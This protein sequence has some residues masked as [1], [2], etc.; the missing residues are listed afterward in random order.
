MRGEWNIKYYI[1]NTEYDFCNFRRFWIIFR[2]NYDE[3]WRLP[4][5]SDMDS[6][7][8]PLIVILFLLFNFSI[9]SCIYLPSA[10]AVRIGISQSPLWRPF[11]VEIAIKPWQFDAKI[12]K[13]RIGYVVGDTLYE[14]SAGYY[15]IRKPM[16][17]IPSPNT[18]VSK[19][20]QHCRSG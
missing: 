16:I 3:Y 7:F 5:I 14:R 17:P 10:S 15:F 11:L 18:A 6:K 4:K 13:G 9:Y 20:V 1:N 19:E 12:T 2:N 8:S